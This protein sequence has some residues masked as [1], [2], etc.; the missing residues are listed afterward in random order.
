M[1]ILI[2]LK[3]G[4]RYQGEYVSESETHIVLKDFKLGEISVS[5]DSVAMRTNPGGGGHER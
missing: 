4:Y 5:K 3:N 2:Q 1:K